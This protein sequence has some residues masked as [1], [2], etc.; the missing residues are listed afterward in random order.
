MITLSGA[1]DS[2]FKGQ[3]PVT[4]LGLDIKRT[5]KDRTLSWGALAELGV[6]RSPVQVLADIEHFER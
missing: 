2:F 4:V 1:D 3:R 6:M 5:P